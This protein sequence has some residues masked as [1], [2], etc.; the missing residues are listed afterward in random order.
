MQNILSSTLPSTYPS[1][2]PS[3]APTHEVIPTNN[4]SNNKHTR[5]LRLKIPVLSL[6]RQP[7]A[8]VPP[9][10]TPPRP[11]LS[12]FQSLATF[13]GRKSTPSPTARDLPRGLRFTAGRA[14]GGAHRREDWM[15]LWE[16][17][18]CAGLV[19]EDPVVHYSARAGRRSGVSRATPGIGKGGSSSDRGRL[20]PHRTGAPAQQITGRQPAA[21]FQPQNPFW[22]GWEIKFC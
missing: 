18:T 19:A 3:A 12:R 7:H 5:F 17:L 21:C 6:L 22:I 20:P 14:S 15:A 4:T 1:C 16:E 2:S 8:G 11:M 10:C 9:F 13:P